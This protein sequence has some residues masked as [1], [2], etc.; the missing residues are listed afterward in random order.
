MEADLMTGFYESFGSW[1]SEFAN[2][3]S[4]WVTALASCQEC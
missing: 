3:T 4:A 2:G 1:Q